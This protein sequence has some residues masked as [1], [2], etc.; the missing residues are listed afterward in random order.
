[1]AELLGKTPAERLAVILFAAVTLAL[2]AA[3]PAWR[4]SDAPAFAEETPESFAARVE[5][6]TAGQEVVTPPPGDV[7]LLAERF[8][9]RPALRLKAGQTYRLHLSSIDGV[10]SLAIDGRE[11]LLVPGQVRVLTI[12]PEAP[13]M[14]DIRCNEYCGLGHNKMRG[15]IEVVGE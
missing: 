12:T 9:F 10:H 6:F 2:L 11:V 4:M 15:T 13:G 7:P 5:A 8:R 1:M 3:L 14:L